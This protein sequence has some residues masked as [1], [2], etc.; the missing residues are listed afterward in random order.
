MAEVVNPICG[1][2]VRVQLFLED[3]RISE[4][5]L[6]GHGCALSQAA[7]SITAA[8]ISG[9]TWAEVR[10]LDAAFVG[11]LED[12]G[13]PPSDLGDLRAFAGVSRL[14]NRVRCALLVWEALRRLAPAQVT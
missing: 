12:R 13:P 2:V 9:R 5:R 1:D 8:R 3:D 10:A 6:G 14:P 4:V 11:M 7:A